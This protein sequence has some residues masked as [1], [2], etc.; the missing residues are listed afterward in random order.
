MHCKAG[1]TRS[2]TLVGCYLMAEN[3][4]SPEQ[5]VEFMRERRPHI[6]LHNKQ[7]EALREYH[8]LH[9]DSQQ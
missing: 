3:G 1:R 9:V 5:A 7:W 6:L 4:W 2:A 8:R